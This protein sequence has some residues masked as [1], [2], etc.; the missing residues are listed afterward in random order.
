M[1]QWGESRIEM[2]MRPGQLVPVMTGEFAWSL[3]SY[4]TTFT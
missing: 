3:E 2:A 4:L 1:T